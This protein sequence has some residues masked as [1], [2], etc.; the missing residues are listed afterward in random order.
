MNPRGWWGWPK[1]S[2]AIFL[3]GSALLVL[4]PFLGP[5]LRLDR[6][7]PVLVVTGIVILLY[8]IET[9]G[10]RLEIARQTEISIQPLVIAK[11][12][13]WP[14]DGDPVAEQHGGLV[15]RNIGHG[16]ALFVHVKD[17]L[18]HEEPGRRYVATC[19][20]IDFI[21]PGQH[22]AT[23]LHLWRENAGGQRH[24]LRHVDVQA[25]LDPRFASQSY[26]VTVSYEDI[27]GQPWESVVQTGRAGIRLLHPPRKGAK[28]T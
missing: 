19:A 17:I 6:S 5:A 10:M 27:N 13:I 4:S 23:E 22:A 7:I 8:T 24:D 18:I 28:V 11:L 1:R 15:L 14:L 21:E 3:I 12:D 20:P 2:W 9:Q 25:H 16:I 26:E